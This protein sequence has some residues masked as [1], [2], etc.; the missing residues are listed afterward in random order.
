[1]NQDNF[2]FSIVGTE[3][4]KKIRLVFQ[5]INITFLKKATTTTT[6]K[7]AG[8]CGKYLVKKYIL[9]T[10]LRL[11]YLKSISLVLF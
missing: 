10:V 6:T 8:K 7:R 5:V 4:K 9:A 1:M 3:L 11:R 2:F